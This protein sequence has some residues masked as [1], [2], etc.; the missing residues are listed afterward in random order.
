[1]IAQKEAYAQSQILALILND[2]DIV[3]LLRARS[4]LGDATPP[5][6]RKKINFEVTY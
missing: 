2:E 1:M 6:E 3:T 4:F 5:L